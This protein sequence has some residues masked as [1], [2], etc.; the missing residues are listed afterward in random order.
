MGSVTTEIR[1]AIAIVTFDN[2][3]RMNAIDAGVAEGLAASAAELKR[4]KDVGALVLRGAGEKSFSAGV[5]LKFV[6]G[7]AKRA[8][9][10]AIVEKGVETPTATAGGYSSPC[11]PTSAS[12][13]ARSSCACRQ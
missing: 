12:E 1:G 9:G 6:E 10:F 7:F 13:T 8:E 11:R 5:D 4:R 2:A 3:A